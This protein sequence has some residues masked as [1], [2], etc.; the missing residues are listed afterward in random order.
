MPKKDKDLEAIKDFLSDWKQRLFS[1]KLYYIENKQGKKVPFIPNRDQKYLYNN[2]HY[3]NAIWKARQLW[4]STAIDIFLLD[5]TMFNANT[6]AW[7]IAHNLDDAKKLFK[8]KIKFPYDNLW[9]LDKGSAQYKVWQEIKRNIKLVANNW[10][11]LEFSNGSS[12]YVSTSFRSWTLQFLH[13]SEFWK[14][15]SKYPEKAKE[16]L[17]GAIEAVWEWGMIFIESTAEWKNDFYVIIKRAE[18]LQILWKK[19]NH[20]EPKL[21]FVA[22][23]ENPDYSLIDSET[24]LTSE[25]INYFKNMKKEHWITVKVD[26]AKWWQ[27]KRDWLN[28]LMWREYPSYLDEAFEVIVMWA[29]F[30]KQ[31][32]LLSKEQRFCAVPYTSGFKVY[33]VWDLWMRDAKDMAFFQLIWKEV[34]IIKWWRWSDI[35]YKDYIDSVVKKLPYSVDRIFLPHDAVKR[36]ETDWSNVR[37]LSIELWYDTHVLTKSSIVSWID[38]T[39]DT[40]SRFWINKQDCFQP[41]KIWW[42]RMQLSLA[43]M[44]WAFQ[45]EFDKVHWIGLGKPKH[46]DASH[47][48]DM[49]RYLSQ[50]VKYIEEEWQIEI[51]EV[52]AP[53]NDDFF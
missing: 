3:Y 31:L 8:S 6:N 48:W 20:L 9:W 23:W 44:L 45:E 49:I 52:Y 22:W 18:K 14:I 50:A 4:Y 15:A 13:I 41:I 33:M 17:S 35:S 1:W 27:V 36:N 42:E 47:T 38:L 10:S 51:Q 28:E 24:V 34:R 26:Q 19:L 37:D 2:L 16:I 46:N 21:F 7:I 5:Q 40:F 25:T 12:I 53:N 32:E 11:T 29:Y 30:K 39:R 43:D